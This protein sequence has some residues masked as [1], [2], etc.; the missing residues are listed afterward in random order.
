LAVL[1]EAATNQAI[2]ENAY[3]LLHWFEHVLG[4]RGD[5]G[6][7]SNVKNL[8]SQQPLLD[9]IGGVLPPPGR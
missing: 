8:L 1:Q 6:D 5:T 4:D 3:E 2:Q 9:G 7:G